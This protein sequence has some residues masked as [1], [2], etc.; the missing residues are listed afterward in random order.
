MDFSLTEGQEMLRETARDFLT[1]ACPKSLVREMGE[2]ARGHPL[3]LWQ[4]MSKLG[5]MGVFIPQQY[6]GAGMSFLDLV[7]LL[8]EMDVQSW[9]AVTYS[10]ILGG[11][12]LVVKQ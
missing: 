10:E 2:D 4:K 3:E 6:G 5:W 12:F 8:E 1:A 11:E 7:V 9:Y